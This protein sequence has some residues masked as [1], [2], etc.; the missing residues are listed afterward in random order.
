MTHEEVTD[1]IYTKEGQRPF[2]DIR[3]KVNELFR[4][5]GTLRM[6]DITTYKEDD[7]AQVA[8]FQIACVDRLVELGE[9]EEITS[10]VGDVPPQNRVFIKS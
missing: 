2:L 7:P 9:I 6:A 5:A 10:F 3:D 4:T 8:W 1:V